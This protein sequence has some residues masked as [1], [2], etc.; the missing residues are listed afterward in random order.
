MKEIKQVEKLVPD[1]SVIIEGILSEKVE[2]NELSFKELLIHEAVMAELESQANKNRETGY[3]GLE[4]I[5][6]LIGLQEKHKFKI[7]YK[8][9]RPTDFEIKHAN[10]GEIDSLIRKLA[11]DEKATL[12]TADRVQSLVAEAKGIDVIFYEIEKIEVKLKLADFFDDETMSVHLKE[13][14]KAF[15]KKGQPGKW[16]F[17]EVSDTELTKTEIQEIAKEIMEE[18]SS[19]KDGF[20]EIERKGSSIVQLGRFRIVIARPPFADG[21][22][23]T[24]VR[25]VKILTLDEYHLDQKLEKR[26]KEQAE[27]V[28]IAGAP[29]HG[30]S[31]FA[32]AL[33]NYYASR[34]KIVKTVEAPRDLVLGD[35]VTQYS[36]SHGSAEEIHD[37][38]LLSRPDYTIFD[39]MRNT[40]DFRLF[41][42]LRLSGVGMLGVI[43]ATNPVDAIQ[44]F[45]GRIELG[46][47]PHVIDTVIFIRNGNVEKVFSV[48]M[49]VK[50]PA[51]M[52]EADLARPVV[53]VSDFIS[54]KTEYEIYSYG[55]ETVV[56]PVSGSENESNPARKLAAHMVKD[57]FMD[58]VDKC[59]VEFLSDNKCKVYIPEYDIA[60]VIGKQGKNIEKIEDDLGLSIDIEELGA[61][62]APKKEIKET[63]ADEHKESINFSPLITKKFVELK[64]SDDMQN[65]FVDVYLN[66]QFLLNAKV[67]KK[68]ILKINKKNKIGET[69]VRAINSGEKIELRV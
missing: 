32:Q 36:L 37:I 42:D 2:N 60:K 50:V 41:A 25:P 12:I 63:V 59:E 61:K 28:L 54:G 20:I 11:F 66:G 67:S 3:L 4:Q 58:H 7:T 46:V 15:A 19:K 21:Y 13:N 35:N 68:N 57:Y 6:K 33:A 34:N 18:A 14:V 26:I 9:S 43:H 8:G 53:T 38:L 16:R 52:T 22:E 64:P 30:K 47:I 69:L 48:V 65:M 23:I 5:K 27:G 10:T 62:K 31:T 44:R 55:E 17:V 49:Q 45:I 24:A 29:G 56:V 39:E 1:T 51:G 40:A